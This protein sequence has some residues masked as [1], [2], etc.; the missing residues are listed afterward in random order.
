MSH[1][2]D[3]YIRQHT[4]SV[5][6]FDRAC[7]NHN[8]SELVIVKFDTPIVYQALAISLSLSLSLSL[9][10]YIYIYIYVLYFLC[11]TSYVY[12]VHLGYQRALI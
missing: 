6:C 3:V 10:I 2:C 4:D 5:I 9:S 12:A 1:A 11:K 7:A 8:G